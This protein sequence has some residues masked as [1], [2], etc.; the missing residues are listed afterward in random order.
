MISA[1]VVSL[2]LIVTELVINALKYAFPDW[3]EFAAV[4]VRYEEKDGD[5][6]LSVSDNGVGMTHNGEASE[7]GGLGTSIVN[8]LAHQLDA[9]IQAKS[10][11]EG[12][13]VSIIHAEAH[14]AGVSGRV[15]LPR[16]GRAV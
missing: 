14:F 15:I 13:T 3:K 10:G 9:Q 11:P 8:A 12:M 7:K 5:W 2:G 4:T 1:N 6:Q 16:D